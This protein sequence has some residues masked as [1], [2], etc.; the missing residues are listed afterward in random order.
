MLNIQV[1]QVGDASVLSVKGK[2]NFETAPQLKDAIK[3]IK[4]GISEQ[5][6]RILLINLEGVSFVDSSGLGL[7]VAAR[8]L[9]EK[10]GGRLYLCCIAPQV[11][12]V[13]D[14]TN[15]TN[16]FSIFESEQDALN[17]A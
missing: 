15:L 13:F 3:D 17:S 6:Q 11:K 1:R 10:S 12:K 9:L 16:F 2:V 4:D 5:H 7:L 8:N 14:Q